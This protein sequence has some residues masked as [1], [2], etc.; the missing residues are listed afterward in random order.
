MIIPVQ[1]IRE[2]PI[3]AYWDSEISSLQRDSPTPDGKE[4][5]FKNFFYCLASK[6]AKLVNINI[7]PFKIALA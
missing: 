7:N 2:I 5:S 3:D 4:K 1:G 6:T